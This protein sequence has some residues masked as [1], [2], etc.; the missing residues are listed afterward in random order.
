MKR[1]RGSGDRTTTR[2]SPVERDAG[3]EK[4]MAGDEPAIVLMSDEGDHTE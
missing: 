4:K 3:A 2:A 1:S